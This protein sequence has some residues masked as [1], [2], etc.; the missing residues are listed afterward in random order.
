MYLLNVRFHSEKPLAEIQAMSEA[1][2]SAFRQVPGLQEKFYVRNEESGEVGGVYL[3]DSLEHLE[4]YVSG[5]IMQAMPERFA[6]RD[7][8]RL[9]ILDVRGELAPGNGGADGERAIG[10]VRFS[11]RLPLDQLEAMSAGS[12]D[13]YA[14]APGLLRVLRCVDPDT[15]RVGGMYLWDSAAARE[16]NLTSP[17]FAQVPELFQVEGE[18]DVE[19]LSVELALTD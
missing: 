6:M 17:Q 10:S 4:A 19:R 9:E 7:E 12:M 8:P 11:S 1:S 18:V 2:R 13:A 15:G 16:A 14:Q 5:P 3:F